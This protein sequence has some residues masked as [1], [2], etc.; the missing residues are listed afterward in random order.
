M[1]FVRQLQYKELSSAEIE[2][3]FERQEWSAPETLEACETITNAVRERGDAALIEL[4]ERFDRVKLTPDRLRVSQ[5]EIDAASAQLDAT[6]RAALDRSIKNIDRFHRTQLDRGMPL[7]EV[8]PG[9]WCG[10]R[11]SAIDS[12]CLYVPRGRGAFSSVACMLAIPAK[13]A[14][15]PRVIVCTPP[16]ADGSVDAAT[17][18]A[19]NQIG[20]DEIYRV[21]GA[22][23]IAAVAYG[24]ET[25]PRCTKVVGPGNIYVSGARQL[26]SNRI[27][28]GPPAGPSES[29]VLADGEANV[30]NVAWNLMIE[31]EHG[32]NSSAWLLT[33]SESLATAVAER[34]PE[35]LPKLT[36]QR[37][38][39][40]REVLSS[41]GGVIVCDNLDEVATLANR[42]AAEHVAIMVREPW[43][44]LPKVNNAGEILLGDYPI[45]SLANYAMGINAILPTGGRAQTY[46][47]VS[48]RDFTKISSIGYLTRS[49]FDSLREFVPTLSQDEGFSA[50]HEAILAWRQP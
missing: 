50:H 9:V 3:L 18:Y 46:S 20:I 45:M 28:P 21:G 49:G 14:G 43:E 5:L 44:L 8:E 26:L 13:L 6:L 19:L 11:S 36:P 10:E 12:V 15:V 34:V 4:T 29:L 30:D 25:V 24:T 32:E 31:A 35:L 41:R 48:I 27:D 1:S 17:L 23:A 47:G 38:A 7:T 42:Y 40:V 33:D 37:Q 2:R 39:Y 22:Q 16:G